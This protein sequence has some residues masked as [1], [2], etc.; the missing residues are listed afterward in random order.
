[1][2]NILALP[3]PKWMGWKLV[4]CLKEAD[5]MKKSENAKDLNYIYDIFFLNVCNWPK[6]IYK[7]YS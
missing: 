1:M 4:Y 3:T 6:I 5:K 7:N 2:E